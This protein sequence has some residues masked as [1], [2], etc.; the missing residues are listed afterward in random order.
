M[1]DPA[2]IR[3]TLLPEIFQLRDGRDILI[4]RIRPDDAPRLSEHFSRLSPRTRRLRFFAPMRTLQTPFAE[5]LADVDFVER[6][7]FV[8]AYPGEETLRGVGRY[9]QEAR[10]AVEVAF[11][12]DDDMHGLG[13]GTELL[14]QLAALARANGY[15]WLTAQVLEENNEMLAVFHGS[16][17]PYTARGDG[18]VVHVRMDL[19]G[20]ETDG[21]SCF[22]NEVQ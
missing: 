6:A 19:G 3:D 4:R 15:R 13:L 20:Q 12:I 1:R 7:A 5:R 16:G 18:T 17:F 11:V 10:D 14:Y 2:A 21:R 22:S 8:A 9:A